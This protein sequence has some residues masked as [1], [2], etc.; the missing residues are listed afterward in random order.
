MKPGFVCG[1]VR[2]AALAPK[3]VPQV[4]FGPGPEAAARAAEALLDIGCEALVSFGTAGGLDPAA[5]SGALL[6][7]HVVV[8]TGADG[9]LARAETAASVRALF[10]PGLSEPLF[11]SDEPLL[12]PQAKA[13]LFALSRAVAVDM[14][15][16]AVARV[17]REAGVPFA[18]VRAVADPADRIVPTW[19]MGGVNAKG[20]TQAAAIIGALLRSPGRIGPL[21]RLARDAGRAEAA[22]KAAASAV[23]PGARWLSEN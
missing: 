2:E 15:S 5:F 14:E 11:G 23:Q 17:A 8:W 4:C 16:H 19:A 3:A 13:A 1:L 12:T 20:E 9:T 6:T 18:V 22:L 21:V 7:P 10:P